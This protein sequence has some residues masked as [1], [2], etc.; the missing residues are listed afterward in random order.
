MWD[1]PGPGLE[2]VSPALAG[3]FLTTAP[4]GKPCCVDLIFSHQFLSEHLLY[5]MYSGWTWFLLSWS[6]ESRGKL[7]AHKWTLMLAQENYKSPGYG[8]N[9]EEG[10]GGQGDPSKQT[11]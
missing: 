3:G 4:P 7:M 10:V 9:P 6:S 1:L 8:G 11:A 2:P 5:T